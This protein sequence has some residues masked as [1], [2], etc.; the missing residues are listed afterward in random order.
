MSNATKP[1]AFDAWAASKLI[2][3]DQLIAALK[4]ERREVFQAIIEA[5]KDAME[6]VSDDQDDAE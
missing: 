3:V 4:A 5:L 6:L 1:D 2:F